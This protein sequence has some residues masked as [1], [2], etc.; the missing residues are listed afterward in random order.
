MPVGHDLDP[1]L[2]AIGATVRDDLLELPARDGHHA[3]QMRVSEG[4]VFLRESTGT[5]WREEEWRSARP[6]QVFGY[7]VD[8]SGVATWLRNRGANVLHLALASLGR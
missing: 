2:R 6:D 7:F 1:R 4:I 8:D 3:R 5:T